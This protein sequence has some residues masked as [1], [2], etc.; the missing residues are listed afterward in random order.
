MNHMAEVNT[1]LI[2]KKAIPRIIKA[3][4][5]GSLTYIIIYFLPLM[6]YPSEILPIDYTT[7]LLQFAVI[8]VFFAVVGVL[9][10]GTLLGYGFG[11][12]KA[13]VIIAYF[14]VISGY[15]IFSVTLPIMEIPINLTVDITVILLMIISVNLLD[16]AKNL[17]QAITLLNEKSTAIELT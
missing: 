1:K 4:V 15:G 11:I 8:A 12:A 16:I 7:E 13:I 5:W 9:F 2:I 14:F 10:A 6:L 17:L 3:A